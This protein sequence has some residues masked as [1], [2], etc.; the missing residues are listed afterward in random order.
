M[1]L[2]K[3]KTAIQLSRMTL[4]PLPSDASTD[5]SAQRD[6]R[7]RELFESGVVGMA[8]TSPQ[9]GW[10]EINQ[11]LCDMLGYSHAELWQKSWTEITHPDD[12]DSNLRL[13]EK[14]LAG[15]IDGYQLSKRYLRKDGSVV[16]TE[17]S[18]RCVR[19]NDG[20]V[21][22]LVAVVEDV[23]ERN[24]AKRA[25][26]QREAVQRMA[27]DILSAVLAGFPIDII[28]EN[29]LQQLHQMLPHLRVA[30]NT[31]DDRGVLTVRHSIGPAHWP[32]GS[33]DVV[34]LEQPQIWRDIALQQ[35]VLCITDILADARTQPFEKIFARWQT[36]ALLVGLVKQSEHE[37]GLLTLSNILPY[38]FSDIEID[39]VKEV[40]RYF[41]LALLHHSQSLRLQESEERLSLALEG[42][43]LGVWDWSMV[44]GHFIASD[45]TAT[46]LNYEP[47]ELPAHI[48]SYERITHI[49]DMPRFWASL[50]D[51]FKERTPQLE[52]EVRLRAK[53]GEWA[54]VL[55]RGRVIARSREGRALRMCGTMQDITE[56]KAGERELI[57]AKEQA[58]AATR[59]KSDF[60][61]TMSHE[62][63]TPMNGVLGMASL[64]AETALTIEQREYTQ[65]IQRSGEALLGII[66]DILDLSK[67]E[68]GRLTLEWRPMDL[69]ACVDDVLVLFSKA[70]QE[71]ALE[72]VVDIDASA[73]AQIIGDVTRI[74][75]ILV[76]LVGNAIKFTESGEIVVQVR[77]EWHLA[78]DVELHFSVR[79]T[80]IGVSEEKLLHLFE[81]FRQADSSTTRRFGGTGLGLSICKRLIEAMGGTIRVTSVAGQGADFRFR[82]PAV[83][84]SER[85]KICHPALQGKNVLLVMHNAALLHALANVVTASGA[86]VETALSVHDVAL[87][88]RPDYVLLDHALSEGSDIVSR[89]IALHPECKAPIL[90]LCHQVP[91]YI[92]IAPSAY[93]LKP[94][95]QVALV[96]ALTRAQ[97]RAIDFDNSDETPTPQGDKLIESASWRVLLA[98]DNLT[99]QMIAMRMLDKVGCTVTVANNGVEALQALR[100]Q[101][102]DFVL[103]DMQMPLMDGLEATRRITAEWPGSHPPIIALTANAMAEDRDR[104]LDAG[105][106]DFLAKPI[107]LQDLNRIITT[108]CKQAATSPA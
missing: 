102:F 1:L 30:Y 34:V 21:E 105:M 33:G 94:I 39:V 24:Q 48:S 78:R 52:C 91:R 96:D 99:N 3:P 88:R 60:L 12:L 86:Q 68:A 47:G 98:E 89:F 64:L 57:R 10:L 51:C 16:D 46:L 27:N 92:S 69:I 82:L 6:R 15:E 87:I 35:P 108:W 73:P 103:M 74:R 5:S 62:I 41:S 72:L 44:D 54:W 26:E 81:P 19:E 7:F 25:L 9:R 53:S 18:V 83:A 13:Y 77:A 58:E 93:I 61:A 40:G 29:S 43:D 31:I 70:A 23:S 75:Q 66:N 79:D 22:Y 37:M 97:A 49:D 32:D 63:R 42:A 90:L 95:R 76:N 84:V 36:R 71:K 100:D 20:Q 17:L 38:L 59:A 11:R 2:V 106:Q 28:I 101:Q 67:I 55:L 56:R 4:P 45:R 104:C 85:Q 50:V 80:G 107:R 8:I 14:M 65:V